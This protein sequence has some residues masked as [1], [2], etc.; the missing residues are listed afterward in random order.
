MDITKYY[1]SIKDHYDVIEHQL[2]DGPR[3]IKEILSKCLKSNPEREIIK[4]W[5]DID[6]III[7]LAFEFCFIKLLDWYSLSKIQRHA[8]KYDKF[9]DDTPYFNYLAHC[10]IKAKRACVSD[11]IILYRAVP[12]MFYCIISKNIPIKDDQCPGGNP[13][14]VIV[15]GDLT[16]FNYKESKLIDLFNWGQ[17]HKII[18]IE[19]ILINEIFLYGFFKLFLSFDIKPTNNLKNII[20]QTGNLYFITELFKKYGSNI[21]EIQ[22]VHN[23]IKYNKP[24]ILE[25]MFNTPAIA[26]EKI[27]QQSHPRGTIMHQP[28]AKTQS[29]MNKLFS[30]YLTNLGKNFYYNTINFN[31]T[32]RSSFKYGNIAV[33]DWCVEHADSIPE[34]AKYL[35]GEIHMAWAEKYNRTDLLEWGE[36]RNIFPMALPPETKMKHGNIFFCNQKYYDKLTEYRKNMY[37]RPVMVYK[38]C[39]DIININHTILDKKIDTDYGVRRFEYTRAHHKNYGIKMWDNYTF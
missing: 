34:I 4:M 23:A 39:L 17:K 2:H 12:Q 8:C 9:N 32:I 29:I 5:D 28:D 33:M 21:F 13:S 19:S 15:E 3:H 37:R 7:S 6:D 25:F 11:N 31:N 27:D 35:P 38:R 16:L 18:K 36:T 22:D 24:E 10:E 14:R 20:I 26:S 30:D 1:N